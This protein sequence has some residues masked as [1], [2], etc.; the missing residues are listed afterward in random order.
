MSCRQTPS[1]PSLLGRSPS[2]TLTPLPTASINAYVGLKVCHTPRHSTKISMPLPTTSINESV[3]LQVPQAEFVSPLPTAS[4]GDS[5]R[6]QV[7]QAPKYK[8]K[9]SK[10]LPTASISD[11]VNFSLYARFLSLGLGVKLHFLQSLVGNE[12]NALVRDSPFKYGLSPFIHATAISFNPLLLPDVVALLPSCR[13]PYLTS[14]MIIPHPMMAVLMLPSSTMLATNSYVGV[15]LRLLDE[16]TISKSMS[17]FPD[18]VG[19]L[20]PSIN[21]VGELILSRH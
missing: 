19:P 8:A 6:L 14:M 5:V 1:T 20:C 15:Y 17:V 2:K 3:G 21:V 4:I 7:P 13:V 10:P 11:Y 9:L 18:D 16:R 12:L